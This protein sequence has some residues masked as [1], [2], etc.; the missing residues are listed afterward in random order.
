MLKAARVPPGPKGHPVLGSLKEFRLDP[1]RLFVSSAQE[2][3]DVV[4]FRFGPVRYYFLRH[5]DHVQHVLQTNHKNYGKQ[6]F[7]WKNMKPLLGEGLLTSD[8]D[9]WLRQRRIAQ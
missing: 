2:L 6:T 9:F 4:L 1:L 3:G 7:G 5:P 8:G